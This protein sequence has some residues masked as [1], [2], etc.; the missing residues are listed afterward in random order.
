MRKILFVLSLVLMWATFQTKAADAPITAPEAGKS[1]YI[2]H[3]SGMLMSWDPSMGDG[4]RLTMYNLGNNPNQKWQFKAVEGKEGVYTIYNEVMKQYLYAD[5]WAAALGDNVDGDAYYFSFEISYLPEQICIKD[6]N[7]YLGSDNNNEGGGI[8]M[9]KGN[10]DGKC[11]FN[12]IEAKEGFLTTALE[13]AIANAEKAKEGNGSQAAL[14]YLDA[15]IAHAHG[16]MTGATS[17]NEI[18]AEVDVVKAAINNANAVKTAVATAEEAVVGDNYG[19]YT[20]ADFNALKAAI[21]TAEAALTGENVA[22]AITA[23][24]EAVSTFNASYKTFVPEAGKKYYVYQVE[25]GRLLSNVAGSEALQWLDPEMTEVQQFSF[26]LVDGETNVYNVVTNDGKYVR[27]NSWHTQLT[28]DATIYEAKWRFDLLDAAKELFMIRRNDGWAVGLGTDPGSTSVFSDKSNVYT[29]VMI[30]EAKPGMVITKG[31]ENLIASAKETVANAVVGDKTW[32]YPQAAVDALNA[33]IAAAETALPGLTEQAKVAETTAT[34]QAAIDAFAAEKILP[35]FEPKAGEKYRFSVNKY[36]TKYMTADAESG[37]LIDASDYEAGKA[38][39]HWEFVAVEGGYKVVNNGKALKNDFTLGELADGDVFVFPYLNQGGNYFNQFG[40]VQAGDNTKALTFGSGKTASWQTLD[41]GNPAHQGRFILVDAAND[42]NRTAL[43]EAISYA[44]EWLRYVNEGK[45]GNEVGMWNDAK[46]KTLEES[47][48]ASKALT[49][50]TQEEV[51]ARTK[52]QNDITNN[53]KDNP[54]SVEKG[55]LDKMMATLKKAI[56]EAVVGIAVGEYYQSKVD[57]MA[58]Q[59]AEFADRAANTSDQEA[60]DALQNEVFEYVNALPANTE[61][62]KIEDVMEDAVECA[63]VLADSVEEDEIGIDKGQYDQA[64]IDTFRKAIDNAKNVDPTVEA[65]NTLQ[66][67]R[68]AF[69]AG[70]NTVDRAALRAAITAAKADDLQNL[71]AGEFDGNYPQAAIT[72]RDEALT[73]AE[74]ALADKTKTQ[75]EIDAAAK[76]LNTAVADLKKAKVVIDFKALDDALAVA[77]PILAATTVVGEGEG[78]IA[79]AKF[80]AFKAEINA[81]KA[82]DRAAINQADVTAK[83]EALATATTAF[84]ADVLAASGLQNA[85]DDAAA[86]TEKATTGLKPGNYPVTAVSALNKAI[87][88]ARTVLNDATAG[89]KAMIDAVA[90]LK[91]AVEKFNGSVIAPNDVTALTALVKEVEEAIAAGKTSPLLTAAL[92]EAKDVLA[93]PDNYTA[94]EVEE[95]TENLQM[96]YRMAGVN[97]ILVGGLAIGA[98]DGCIVVNGIEGETF[99]AVY[100]LSGNSVV[101]VNAVENFRSERLAAGTYIVCVAANGEQHTVKVIVK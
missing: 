20:Q 27:W 33:A 67:A 60:V 22:E 78:A 51:D 74:A 23:L 45:R 4:Q 26:A 54:N 100:T 72:A 57:E 46:C 90:A 19:E 62:Q 84:R 97:G 88:A 25:T 39:Q 68:A 80:D 98:N 76:A 2:M 17:Q 85:I 14:A 70:R 94:E 1:Y 79:Q 56:D 99:I 37:A 16:V 5:G 55:D 93:N 53:F 87:E 21:A 12:I 66:A 63:M 77:E 34:L 9:N 13:T 91:A 35:R 58:A 86:L 64:V 28:D 89:Q 50:A 82:I 30:M 96:A 49:G 24:N 71:T 31:L 43:E 3:S 69:V 95:V 75:E 52:E 41:K 8:Y 7:G 6:K 38:A 29:R 10:R 32:N 61:E 42:P 101:N 11:L 73:A 44:E 40:F 48:A 59:Y 83:A 15:A 47:I 36:S 81:A 65:L 92:A 18:N